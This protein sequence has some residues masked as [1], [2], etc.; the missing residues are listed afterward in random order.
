MFSHEISIKG[1]IVQVPAI[2]YGQNIITIAGKFLKIAEIFDEYWI[3]KNEVPDPVKV[4][5]TLSSLDRK[6]DL[7][8]FTQRVPDTEPR[9]DYPMEYVNCAVIPLSTYENWAR[10]QI[11]S[12]TRRNIGASEKRGIQVRV[13]PYDDDYVQG[14]M[15]IYNES[16]IRAGR[17]YWH[18]GKDFETVQKENGTYKERSIYLAAYYDSR[19]IG[20]MKIVL[21]DKSAAIMQILS[22]MEFRDKRP[23]NALMAT[24][25]KE[26]CSRGMEYLQ[27]E[28]FIYGKKADSSLTEFKRNNGFTKMDLPK[29][30]VPLTSKGSFA[31][32]MDFHKDL[33][34][35]LPYGLTSRLL[36]MRTKWYQYQAKMK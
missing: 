11:S 30:Y 19:M 9:Y 32:K 27:Y 2:H 7:F 15:S 16:P 21:D 1:K 31:I 18:Y 5:E 3:R 4:I 29:Y 12:M 10:K 14:I 22:M 13:S 20:Y 26:C 35:K 23:N 25:V 24:A 28:S 17:K 36:E 33:K 6:P 34:D 8:T